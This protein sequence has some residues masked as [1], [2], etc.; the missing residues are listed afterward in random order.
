M[1]KSTPKV[2]VL[3]S[4]YNGSRYLKESIDSILNQTFTDLEFII[5]DDCSTDD[6]GE[7]ISEYAEKDQRI[8]LIKNPENIGLTKS[9]NKGLKIAKGEYVA[10][11]DADDISLPERLTKQVSLLNKEPEVALVSCNIALIDP[12]GNPIEKQIRACHPDLVSL[13]LLFYNHLGGHSQV[14]F[15][16]ELVINLG[17]YCESFRY[18][19]D[20]ELWCRIDKVGRIYI[21]PEILL[22]QR[23]HNQSITLAKASEQEAYA[24]SIVQNNIS[25]LIGKEIS[26]E[27]AKYLKEF[28]VG[29][30]GPKS[31]LARKK[32]KVIH[33][34]MKEIYQAY[35]KQE[36]QKNVPCNDIS[37]HLH[38][39]TGKQFVLWGKTLNIRYSLMAKVLVSL[40]AL[41]W[42]PLEVLNYA[43]I[44]IRSLPSRAL[45]WLH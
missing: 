35:L 17:G 25:Q 42:R 38:F 7:I 40:Y 6:S 31:A 23:R 36:K 24:L 19:Q 9:L 27:E 26:I 34:R 44:S 11:Q 28:W 18:S 33:S 22:Q 32:T 15:R 30:W 12:D 16:R 2:S 3:M 14:I 13:H 1:S 43:F 39:M 45:S 29:C 21:L 41:M 8:V 20:Y 4:V 37:C 10:R 5:I